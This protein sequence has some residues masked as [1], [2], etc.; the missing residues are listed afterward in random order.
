MLRYKVAA[1]KKE[2]LPRADEEI[3][4]QPLTSQD[5]SV[6]ARRCSEHSTLMST[7]CR[8]LASVMPHHFDLLHQLDSARYKAKHLKQQSRR[9]PVKLQRKIKEMMTQLKTIL[10]KM[11]K[12][13]LAYNQEL[14][15]SKEILLVKHKVHIIEHAFQHEWHTAL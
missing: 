7:L 1:V 5:Y 8:T 14:P 9:V 15:L 12:E 4:T 11:H 10:L 13:L 3:H 6:D 2:T